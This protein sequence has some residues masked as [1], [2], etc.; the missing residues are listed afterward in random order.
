M[1]T[2]TV[3][4]TEDDF[5]ARCTTELIEDEGREADQATAMCHAFWNESQK[6]EVGA[7]PKTNEGPAERKVIPFIVTKVNEAQGIVEHTVAIFGNVDLGGDKIWPGAFTKTITERAGSIR[8]LD[9]HNTDSIMRVLGRPIEMREITRA[10]LPAKVLEQ[11]PDAEGALM[12]STQFLMDT[13]EGRG[14][15]SRV[16]SGSIGEYSIGYDPITVDFE[17]VKNA[18]GTEGTVR[19]LRE[20]RLWEYS[21]VVFAMNPATSTIGAKAATTEEGG[22]DIKQDTT[23]DKTPDVTEDAGADDKEMTPSGP[24]RRLGDVLQGSIHRTFTTIADQLYIDGYIDR[25]Q[26]IA[27]SALIGSALDV[28]S[29]GIPIEIAEMPLP[30]WGYGGGYMSGDHEAET[31]AGRVL[32][33]RNVTRLAAALATL[34]EVLEDAGIEIPGFGTE[35]DEK[36]TTAANGLLA[37]METETPNAAGPDESSPTA[38]GDAGNAEPVGEPLTEPEAV[39]SVDEMDQWL[40]EINDMLEE[41]SDE[42]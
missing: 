37:D 20:I 32:A 34:I 24:Q 13:Q 21:P 36:G 22:E 2:P 3:N 14:A 4:E 23:E 9:S 10:Q 6:S 1:P 38:T 25:E 31:K 30:E 19:N 7:M 41:V 42:P 26:R 18:D 27:L 11:Y 28:L 17:T 35:D 29:A 33:A 39:M 5:I 8:V 40:I 15:Y 12:A 16:A